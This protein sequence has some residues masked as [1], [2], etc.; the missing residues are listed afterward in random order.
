LQLL[1]SRLFCENDYWNRSFLRDVLHARDTFSLGTIHALLG[2]P[3]VE[4]VLGD[5][6][7]EKDPYYS[8]DKQEAEG[9][10]CDECRAIGKSQQRGGEAKN[11]TENAAK[12]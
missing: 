3:D 11:C 12:S 9:R 2:L 10:W 1:V 7:E 6:Q 5:K 8:D 4:H